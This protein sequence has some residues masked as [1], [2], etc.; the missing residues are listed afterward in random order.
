MKH[1]RQYFNDR[2]GR[3]VFPGDQIVYA[4][5][6]GS[7]L[8]LNEAVVEKI[9]QITDEGYW[10]NGWKITVQAKSG[11][12]KS[13]L[14]TPKRIVKVRTAKEIELAEREA[15]F[16]ASPRRVVFGFD[17]SGVVP[18]DNPEPKGRVNLITFGEA[19][20]E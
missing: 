17:G 3:P 20:Y 6:R 4:V 7:S 1:E 13:F 8:W 9:E 5:R 12:R 18:T 16:R 2:V 15:E 19:A 14:E 10:K 11:S